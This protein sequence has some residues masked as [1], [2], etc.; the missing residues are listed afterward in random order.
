MGLEKGW[1]DNVEHVSDMIHFLLEILQAPDPS[2]LEMFLGRIPMVFNVVILSPHGYFGQA[3]VLGMPDTGGQLHG[4]LTIALCISW[5]LFSIVWWYFEIFLW[6]CFVF[7]QWNWKWLGYPF[8]QHLK[9]QNKNSITQ[10][11]MES[12]SQFCVKRIMII[13]KCLLWCSCF[14][15]RLCIYLT[16]FVPWKMKC[17]WE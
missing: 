13:K 15:Y 1:G 12:F 4:L 6:F 5:D 2:T 3:N 9:L 8:K 11:W 10:Y 7:Q 16:K 17:C 14:E